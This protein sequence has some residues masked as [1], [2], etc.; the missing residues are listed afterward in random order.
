VRRGAGRWGRSRLRAAAGSLGVSLR[1][2][3]MALSFLGLSVI[4]SLRITDRG[5]IDV[6]RSELASLEVDRATTGAEPATARGT[7]ARS[8][9]GGD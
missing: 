3:F 7:S 2:P 9:E 6:D 5:L 4:P 1:T 8:E